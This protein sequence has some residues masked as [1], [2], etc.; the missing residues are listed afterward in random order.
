M[1]TRG[2]QNGRSGLERCLSLGFGHSK[3]LSLNKVFDPSTS[4]IRKGCDGEEAKQAKNGGKEKKKTFL[5]PTN[6]VASQLPE[7]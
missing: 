2:P 7:R 4:S 1:A 6:G 3:Q 5:V